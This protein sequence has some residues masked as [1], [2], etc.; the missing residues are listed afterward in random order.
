[1][2][3]R[4]APP[5]RGVDEAVGE[6]SAADGLVIDAEPSLH[7]AASVRFELLAGAGRVDPQTIA[8]ELVVPGER[9]GQDASQITGF[10]G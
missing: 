10:R 7:A 2:F 3:G 1:M 6:S 5:V 8:H 4:H 9:V